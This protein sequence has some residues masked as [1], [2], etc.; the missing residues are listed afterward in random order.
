MV[1]QKGDENPQI[2]LIFNLWGLMYPSPWLMMAKFG[3]LKQTLNV[4]LIGQISVYFVASE[5][6][7]SLNFTFY[8]ILNF[9]ML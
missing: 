6:Q 9:D 7:K 8:H 5:R 4:H 3:T 2:Y 1:S